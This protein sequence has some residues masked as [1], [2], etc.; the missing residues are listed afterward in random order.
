MSDGERTWVLIG[1]GITLL[2]GFSGLCA[3]IA[4]ALGRLE[5]QNRDLCGP[6]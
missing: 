5:R 3:L 1:L 6:E 4:Y 2:G